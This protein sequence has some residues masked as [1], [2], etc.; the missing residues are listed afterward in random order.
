MIRAAHCA[1]LRIHETFNHSLLSLPSIA[2]VFLKSWTIVCCTF[3]TLTH[4]NWI[5]VLKSIWGKFLHVPTERKYFILTCWGSF[6][7]NKIQSSTTF[8]WTNRN[9]TFVREVTKP[10]FNYNIWLL[11]G[12]EMIITCIL[13]SVNGFGFLLCW[14]IQCNA[15]KHKITAE[16]HAKWLLLCENEHLKAFSLY[17]FSEFYHFFP[18]H[19]MGKLKIT[20]HIYYHYEQWVYLSLK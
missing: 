18:V 19:F 13:N 10:H 6:Y 5:D 4:Q 1:S 7:N 17:N 16:M 15:S 3:L 8:E 12:C 14:H 2:K 20:F 9:K 11:F